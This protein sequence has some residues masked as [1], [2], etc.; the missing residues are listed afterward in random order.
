MDLNLNLSERVNYNTTGFPIYYKRD[1]L[2]N[3]PNF[4][5]EK[6]WHDD[7]EFLV[8]LSGKILYNVNGEIVTI[9][10][11]NG[12]FVNSRQFHFGF[13]PDFSECDFFCVLMHPILLTASQFIEQTYVAPIL[14]D[15]SLPYLLLHKDVEWEAKIISAVKKVFSSDILEQVIAF[16]EILNELYKNKQY[17]DRQPVRTN[18][19]LSVLKD[20][21][22]FI[23]YNY[24]EKISLSDI[25]RAGAVGKTECCNIFKFYTNLTPINFLNDFRLR[26]STELLTKTDM[27][28]SEICYEVGF[29]GASYFTEA[30]TRTF[31][32]SP[33]A[34]RKA[35]SGNP[36]NGA[37]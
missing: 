3:F 18:S 8:V 36:G 1:L 17:L 29:S 19:K 24:K 15:L 13:S 11:G 22:S 30:F 23:Q 5:A 33:K 21:V 26:K 14:K 12:I 2:S 25:A 34:Y 31:R 9:E 20:M 16:Y 27:T 10:E 35:R 7:F 28:I 4:A 32:T 37:D 6:H